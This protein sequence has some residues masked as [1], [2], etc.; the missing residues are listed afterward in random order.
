GA[1]R[2]CDVSASHPTICPLLPYWSS[3]SPPRPILLALLFLSNDSTTSEI[4]T[5][6]LHDALPISLLLYKTRKEDRIPCQPKQNNT[7]RWPTR[8]RGSSPAAGRSGRAFSP[9]PP[10][11]TNIR[12]MNS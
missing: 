11:S 6:S 10:A 8:R 7:R 2:S 9:P 1:S 5:L 3:P 4:Y 12:S